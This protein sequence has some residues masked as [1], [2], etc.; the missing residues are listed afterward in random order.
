MVAS[1]GLVDAENEKTYLFDA[2]PDMVVQIKINVIRGNAIAEIQ[3]VDYA[4]ID[5]TFY[6]GAEMNNRDISQ[7]PHPFIIESLAKFQDL[8]PAEKRKIDFIHSNP[9]YVM[10][11]RNESEKHNKSRNFVSLA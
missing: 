7:T 5:A 6:S 1:I 2:T 10:E 9:N 11:H 8:S 4:F 3:Q